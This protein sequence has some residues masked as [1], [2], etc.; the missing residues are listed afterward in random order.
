[1]R[2]AGAARAHPTTHRDRAVCVARVW[3]LDTQRRTH[4][5]VGLG[6]L[7]LDLDQLST[8]KHP[9]LPTAPPALDLFPRMRLPHSGARAPPAETDTDPPCRTQRAVRRCRRRGQ[10]RW[11]DPRTA[12]HCLGGGAVPSRWRQRGVTPNWGSHQPS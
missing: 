11:G 3:T 8:T 4:S 12:I 2:A 7:P 10:P 5:F 1:M 9:S 6:W